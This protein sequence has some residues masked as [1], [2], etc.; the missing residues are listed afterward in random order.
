MVSY[1]RR[2]GTQRPEL[3]PVLIVFEFEGSV[4]M[5]KARSIITTGSSLLSVAN[6]F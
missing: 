4:Q 1:I 5:N 2:V 6:G 3:R